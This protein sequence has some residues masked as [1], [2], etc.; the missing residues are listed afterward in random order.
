[1]TE[2]L[3]LSQSQAWQCLSLEQLDTMSHLLLV[4]SMLQRRQS[5]RS[6]ALVFLPAHSP[7]LR[8]ARLTSRHLLGQVGMHTFKREASSSRTL[9]KRQ[10]SVGRPGSRA[11]STEPSSSTRRLQAQMPCFAIMC[12][13]TWQQPVWQSL[14]LTLCESLM[15]LQRC[16][17][18]SAQ[19]GACC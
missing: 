18:V 19:E 12:N 13:T 1:M 6:A 15:M 3:G 17:T 2:V 8:L 10:S 4:Q 11:L 16:R 7:H 14:V 9:L 5:P